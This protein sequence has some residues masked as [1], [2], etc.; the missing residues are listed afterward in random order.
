MKLGFGK[1][2]LHR[3]LDLEEL[4]KFLNL[5]AL[6]EVVILVPPFMSP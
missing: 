2:L 5:V 4:V 6:P 3:N 1:W